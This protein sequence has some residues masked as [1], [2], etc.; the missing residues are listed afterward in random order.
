M[1]S[2]MTRRTLLAGL[3]FAP[4]G[5]F[6]VI[7]PF[8]K[9]PQTKQTPG[10]P[11]FKPASAGRLVS[12]WEKKINYAPDSSRGGAIIPGLVG[13]VY[14]FGP[15]IK[16]PVIGDG[17]LIIDLF[18]ASSRGNEPPTMLEQYRFP[19]EVL[20]QF[21]KKDIFGHGYSIFIPWATYRPDITHL[22][23][24]M[25]YDSPKDGS[26]FHQSG[27]FALDHAET[28]ERVKKGMSVSNPGMRLVSQ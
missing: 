3:A 19:A 18:D 6:N 21:A 1:E 17:S 7:R 27:T 5:C 15:D 23:L 14:L 10:A 8:T 11:E 22:F 2:R 26:F 9:D 13:R 16:D 25:R 4:L 24:M 12:T 20:R 28:V